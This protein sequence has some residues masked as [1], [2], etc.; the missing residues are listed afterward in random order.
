MAMFTW[1]PNYH[2]NNQQNRKR[3]YLTYIF[4]RPILK[5]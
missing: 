3:A 4:L 5:P 1:L 2:V